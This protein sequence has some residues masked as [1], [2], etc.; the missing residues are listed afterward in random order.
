MSQPIEPADGEAELEGDQL[1]VLVG[2]WWVDN[3][4]DISNV[5]FDG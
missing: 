4:G 1:T 3:E 5:R 2:L